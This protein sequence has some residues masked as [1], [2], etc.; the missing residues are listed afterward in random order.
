MKKLKNL[1][2]GLSIG[3]LTTTFPY[4]TYSAQALPIIDVKEKVNIK[5]KDRYS[6]KIKGIK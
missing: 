5:G 2:L 3:A 1:A 4:I 6:I